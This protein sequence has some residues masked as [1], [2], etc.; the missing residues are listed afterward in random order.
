MANLQKDHVYDPISK[1]HGDLMPSSCH[2]EKMLW[3]VMESICIVEY[4]LVSVLPN[5]Y[6]VETRSL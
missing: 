5:L 2:S 1:Q 4:Q 3:K 6:K